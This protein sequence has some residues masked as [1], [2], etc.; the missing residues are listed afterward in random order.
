MIRWKWR[1]KR[2][3]IKLGDKVIDKYIGFT[4]VAV[5][6]IEFINKC[7]QF[8]VAPAVNK[9]NKLEDPQG[10]D[11]QSLLI[12]HSKLKTEIKKVVR[13]PTGGANSK[14]RKMRGY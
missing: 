6:R 1:A 10:I 8:E 14:P 3:K 11:E 5:A 4:G 2:K 9:E 7:V 13:K 12:V